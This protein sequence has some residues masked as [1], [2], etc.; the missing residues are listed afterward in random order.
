[1]LTA[2]DAGLLVAWVST[3]PWI[4]KPTPGSDRWGGYSAER[5][6]IA[7]FIAGH[8]IDRLVMLSGDG[9]MLA[10]DDGSH[11][12]YSSHGG[13][14]FPVMQAAALDKQGSRKG[15]PYTQGPFPNR[16]HF[17]RHD[18]QF[19]WM[20]VQDGGGPEICVE[21]RG[22]RQELHTAHVVELIRWRKCFP[23]A[24]VPSR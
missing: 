11:S 5:R 24:T 15:G 7:D 12:D 16:T 14:G 21:W 3:D 19:G 1:M 20:E 6:E 17:G 8:R 9:H 4:E 23:T 18:G 13:A 10:L 22:L 2:Y